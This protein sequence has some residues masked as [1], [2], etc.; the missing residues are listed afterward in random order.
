EIAADAKRALARTCD[1]RDPQ[2]C[3]GA[4]LVERGRH[5]AMRLRGEGVER[6]RAVDGDPE[7]RAILFG[8]HMLDRG[9]FCAFTFALSWLPA[10]PPWRR[11]RAD[12]RSRRARK[13]MQSRRT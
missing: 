1:H 4:E 13:S 9:H 12:S 10:S 2:R 6:S 3:I 7:D 5:L 11:P 8:Q